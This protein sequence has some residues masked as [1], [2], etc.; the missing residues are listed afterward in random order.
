MRASGVQ[1]SV[2][3]HAMDSIMESE[4]DRRTGT[5]SKAAGS[6]DWASSA[7][8]SARRKPTFVAVV[9]AVSTRGCDPRR[10]D[11]NSIGHPISKW[12]YQEVCIGRVKRV[13]A[14]PSGRPALWLPTVA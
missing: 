5:V 2:T 14:L 1:S 7:P 11:S 6:K 10:M 8:L 9:S 4:P 12:Y 13:S 3:Y